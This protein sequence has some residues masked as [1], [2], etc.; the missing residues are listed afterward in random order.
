MAWA[1]CHDLELHIAALCVEIYAQGRME[2]LPKNVA[3][4]NGKLYLK[5]VLWVASMV[6]LGMAAI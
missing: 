2:I 5:H 1:L 3:K 6:H 4:G